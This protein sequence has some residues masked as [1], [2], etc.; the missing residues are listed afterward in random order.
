MKQAVL[1]NATVPIFYESKVVKLKLEN[2]DI[3]MDFEE[4]TENEE[5][6]TKS[7]KTKVVFS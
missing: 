5:E 1:D 6:N 4:V 3:D 7:N 2:S